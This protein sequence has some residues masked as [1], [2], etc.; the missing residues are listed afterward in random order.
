M[1]NYKSRKQIGVCLGP[2][3]IMELITN[4]HGGIG[5]YDR[6][7]LILESNDSFVTV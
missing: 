3:E 5:G 6:N 7:V 2:G 4:V 1:Q